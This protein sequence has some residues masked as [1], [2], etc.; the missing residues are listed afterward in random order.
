MNIVRA[1]SFTVVSCALASPVLG[2]ITGSYVIQARSGLGTGTVSV[3]A[4][5]LTFDAAANGFTFT[6]SG[7]VPIVSPAG[8][9]I[10]TLDAFSVLI[11]EGECSD[12]S[13]RVT[14]GAVGTNFSLTSALSSFG[15]RTQPDALA[16]AQ[17][18]ATDN[19]GSGVSLFGLLLG[20]ASY[21]AGYNGL[22]ADASTPAFARLITGASSN[23]AFGSVNVADASPAAGFT[24]I[25]SNVSS[26]SSMFSF[27][28]TGGDSANASGSF[29]LATIPTPGSVALVAVGGLLAARRRRA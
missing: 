19:D 24:Q 20:G 9:T 27:R 25:A 28:L 4:S 11:R 15:A 5:Q 2:T 21:Q 8:A 17:V 6:Q 23:D 12:V 18:V 26:L 7:A 3:D 22:A 1:L 14:A 13:F 16:T 29:Q 10:G